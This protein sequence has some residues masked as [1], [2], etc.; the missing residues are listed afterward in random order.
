MH[1]QVEF[2]NDSIYLY[3]IQV[4]P[5]RHRHITMYDSVSTVINILREKGVDA[6][7]IPA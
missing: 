4:Y 7:I 6:E 2:D 3:L 1:Y 5:D